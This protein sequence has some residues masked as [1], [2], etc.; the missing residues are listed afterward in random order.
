MD[1]STPDILIQYLDGEL[2]GAEMKDLEK[3]LSQD[4]A[5][6]AQMDN[7]RSAREAIRLYGLKK[8]ISGIHGKMMEE[9]QPAVK[10]ILPASSRKG[11]IRYAVAAAAILVLVIGG[12]LVFNPGKPNAEKL[13]ASHYNR[14]ELTTLRDGNK[15]ETKVEKAY[16]EKKFTEV[17]RIHDAG[18]DHTPVGE[19]LCGAAALEEKDIPKAI[20]CFSEVLEAGRKS[21]EPILKDEAEY[22]LSLSYIRNHDYEEALV[23]LNT[24][25]NDPD[26]KYND[27]VDEKLIRQVER[28]Q[29]K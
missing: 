10:K 16:R 21:G 11:F 4:A 22:Y 28:L 19:F 13:F 14:Y 1:N 9:L 20:K 29:E 3:R 6:Q 7:L 2:S 23:L 25:E 24:I 26:H 17:L 15:P 27:S 12:Y 18:E 8:R 5:M